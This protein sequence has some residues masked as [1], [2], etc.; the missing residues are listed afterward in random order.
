MEKFQQGRLSFGFQLPLSVIFLFLSKVL[1][2][3]IIPC[4]VLLVWLSFL[5]LMLAVSCHV[6]VPLL[7]D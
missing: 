4:Q 6:I 3:P 2:F 7:S 1:G 5:F